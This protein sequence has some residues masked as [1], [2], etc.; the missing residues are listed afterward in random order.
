MKTALVSSIV[1][2]KRDPIELQALLEE[3]AESDLLGDR[4][5]DDGI[6]KCQAGGRPGEVFAARVGH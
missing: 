1:Y 5:H 3:A 2:P 4:R 6:Q